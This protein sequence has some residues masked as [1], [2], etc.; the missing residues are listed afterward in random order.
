[1]NAR[2]SSQAIFCISIAIVSLAVAAFVG[3]RVSAIR[4]QIDASIADRDLDVKA[5]KL[6]G[7]TLGADGLVA[8]VYYMRALQY[9]GD[10]IVNSNAT[11]LDIGDLRSLNAVLLFPLL[12]AATDV[13]PKFK[14][15]F[16][17]GAV[18]LPAIN[19]EDAIR[20]LEKAIAA[21]PTDWRMYQQLGYIY[22]RSKD[23]ERAAEVY[24]AGSLIDGAT[25][26]MRM[27][28]ASM[29]REGG[30]RT[31][32]RAIFSEMFASSDDASIRN[33]AERRLMELDAL[34][35]IDAINAVL[36]QE[37]DRRGMCPTDLRTIAP[38][39]QRATASGGPR[40]LMDNAGHLVDPSGARYLFDIVKCEVAIDRANTKLPTVE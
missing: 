24:S 20:L 2:R 4:P 39:L 5:V 26:F 12:D 28:A 15:A 13:D 6:R 27:M 38:Q 7:F 37:K 11:D 1:M 36:S 23:Y 35:Q 10:K 8:D 22:W 9:I 34:D 21:D 17:Y 29:S 31:T 32:A 30:S 18:V 16:N 40:L 3:E 14:A 19:G 25:P 33:A